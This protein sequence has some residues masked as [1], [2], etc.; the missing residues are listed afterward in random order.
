MEDSGLGY[1]TKE[2]RKWQL[3]R[4]ETAM[5][6]SCSVLG[7]D[8]MFMSLNDDGSAGLAYPVLKH[9]FWLYSYFADDSGC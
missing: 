1:P 6:S 8:Y 5:I 9:C 7:V 2:E 4:A 3:Y